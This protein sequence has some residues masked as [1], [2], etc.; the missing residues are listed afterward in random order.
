MDDVAFS[1]NAFKIECIQSDVH[2][3]LNALKHECRLCHV[4]LMP[5]ILRKD[6]IKCPLIMSRFRIEFIEFDIA[7]S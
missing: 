4:T 1:A 7:C 3:I 5:G 6:V 2:S